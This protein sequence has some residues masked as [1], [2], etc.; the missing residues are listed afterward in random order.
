MSCIFCSIVDKKIPAHIVAEDDSF[1]AFLDIHP[2]Q[3]YHL[4]VIPKVEKESILDLEPGELADM[5]AFAKP[6]AE[7]QM[8]LTGAKRISFTTVGLDV[9]HFHW[10][11]IPVS[12][13]GD[14]DFSKAKSPT[15]EELLNNLKR[16]QEALNS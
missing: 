14:L 13:A 9:D 15:Q 5:Y 12:K 8:R 7:A 4:L 11:L 16:I 6:I 10:H 3:P 2:T 1:L